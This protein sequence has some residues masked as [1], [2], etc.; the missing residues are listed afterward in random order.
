MATFTPTLNDKYHKLFFDQLAEEL[1]RLF[2]KGKCKE[3]GNA[4]VLN[5]YANIY[6][7]NLLMKFGDEIIRSYDNNP[8]QANLN[9]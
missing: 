7:R 3:R 5:S 6:F 9:K 8:S 2:P 1:E 4:L